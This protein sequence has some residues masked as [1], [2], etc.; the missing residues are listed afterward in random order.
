M[1]VKENVMYILGVSQGHDA[2]ACLVKDGKIVAAAEEE[3]FNRI[4]H[5]VGLGSPVLATKFCLNQAGITMDDVD[6]ITIDSLDPVKT[7]GMQL[8]SII[9]QGN[10]NKYMVKGLMRYVLNYYKWKM[11]GNPFDLKELGAAKE[12]FRFVRHHDAHAGSAFRLSGFDKADVLIIDGVGEMDATSHYIGDKDEL[13]PIR[14]LSLPHSIGYF[15]GGV[16]MYLGY[17]FAEGEGKIMGLAPYGKNTKYYDT[18][19]EMITLNSNGY[20]LSKKYFRLPNFP[21]DFNPVVEKFGDGPKTTENIDK[22]KKYR[23]IAFA[24]QRHLE[25]TMMHLLKEYNISETLCLAGG[26]ALNCKMNGHILRESHIK[27]IFIQPA[28]NDAGGSIGSAIELAHRMGAKTKQEMKHV[29]LGPEYTNE[30]IVAMLDNNK[31]P[32]EYHKNIESVAA[33][34]LAKNKI[35]GWY[36]GR[37]EFGPRALGNRSILM[38]PKRAE[39]KDIINATVKYREAYRPFCPSMLDGAKKEYLEEP[40]KSPYMIL[41]F[42]VPKKKQK[43]IPAVVHVDGSCRPQTVERSVNPKYWKLI[44]KFEGETGT[45]VLLNTSFNIRGEPIV[46]TPKEA[47]S[48]YYGTG[49]DYLV[50]GNYL[51]SNKNIS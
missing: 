19:K 45:P 41:S 39:N 23:D 30:Q 25:E 42:Q 28:A 8:K 48:C 17:E 31:V 36:Q 3:R 4:K 26:V 14:R 20:T 2:S 18:L 6:Y 35:V 29:Y 15:Y 24:L 1:F 10:F 5:S 11:D 22:Q 21:I 32:Y 34:L 33:E 43:E 47:V 49:I 27:D 40:Y 13:T 7:Y 16:T 38:S 9:R 50:V 12:K 46:C 44:K 37:M 51:I